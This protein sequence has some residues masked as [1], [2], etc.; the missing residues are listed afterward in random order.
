MP[1]I[2]TRTSDTP[3]ATH[4]A[5]PALALLLALS[6][7]ACK[8][9]PGTA[10]APVATIPSG[11]GAAGDRPAPP[12]AQSGIEAGA[13]GAM[14][15]RR[16]ARGDYLS[17]AEYRKAVGLAIYDANANL[18][19]RGTLPA[20]LPAIVILDVEVDASGRLL[21]S[22]VRRGGAD[23]SKNDVALATLRR[24]RLPAPSANLLDGRGR[25]SFVETW[26]FD[27]QGRFQLM[28]F[29]PAQARE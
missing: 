4:T 12:A 24:T 14:R 21:N 27:P 6:L 28:A 3:R 2:L 25:V 13:P 26:F 5:L 29:T 8:S 7:S 18:A 23:S 22:R 19:G 10:P 20:M 15:P 16:N 11:Q 17:M 1:K 9:P